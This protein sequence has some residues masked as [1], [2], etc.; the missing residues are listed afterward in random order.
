MLF[1]AFNEAMD[2]ER[3]YGVKGKG[4]AWSKEIGKLVKEPK[5]NYKNKNCAEVEMRMNEFFGKSIG[6]IMHWSQFLCGFFP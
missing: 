5:D 3:P 4:F 2:Y 6:R 1:D